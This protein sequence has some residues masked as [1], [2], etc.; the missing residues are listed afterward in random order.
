MKKLM[1]GLVMCGLGLMV[2]CQSG[3]S[4][5]TT[6][7]KTEKTATDT[8][9]EKSVTPAPEKKDDGKAPDAKDKPPA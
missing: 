8:K 6:V 3:S 9:T 5:G 7:K 1:A 2:G 4:S